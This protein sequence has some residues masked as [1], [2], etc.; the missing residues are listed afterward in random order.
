LAPFWDTNIIPE[1]TELSFRDCQ[2]R[3]SGVDISPVSWHVGGT[4]S[5]INNVF[6]HCE[7]SSSAITSDTMP[8]SVQILNNLFYRGSCYISLN[9]PTYIK[10]NLF[11]GGDWISKFN[12][13]ATN[14]CIETNATTDWDFADSFPN[15]LL[16]DT[17]Q[18]QTG[19][20]GRFYTPS[21]GSMAALINSGNG[22]ASAYGLYH[23]TTQTNQ[24]KEAN[25]IVDI[26]YHYV[27]TSTNGIPIDTDNDTIPDYLED[28]NGDGIG[29]NDRFNWT[30]NQ[31]F[32]GI[33]DLILWNQGRNPGVA[34]TTNA[35]SSLINMRVFTPMK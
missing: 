6:D 19:P 29:T 17:V 14:L 7:V 16:L 33:N 28:A 32:A 22:L 10:N 3:S 5:F 8:T 1:I 4:L 31:T 9:P 35:S 21:T 24:A 11:A 30:T 15:S 27:A 23:Y 18:F 13:G 12:S 20:L 34:T 26:G 25:S 2:L